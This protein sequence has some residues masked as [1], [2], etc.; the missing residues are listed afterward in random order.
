MGLMN[1]VHYRWVL[2]RRGHTEAARL[3]G[4]RI[5]ERS[6]VYSRH[7]GTEPWL[8]SIGSGTTISSEVR[9][10]T[11]DGI[12]E[13]FRDSNGRRYRYASVRVGDD[14]FVGLGVIVLP[15]VSIGSRCVVAAGSVVTKSVPDNTVVAGN[16][17]RAIT[18]YDELMARVEMW[19][20]DQD[21]DGRPYR[22]FVDDLATQG[23]YL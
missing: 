3:L 13:L 12:G 14:C 16:P 17:A 22:E 20:S 5:G 15:G 21:R 19:P 11:H 9:F 2:W 8:I 23:E 10:L 4:V 1:S 18:T 6:R 7:F